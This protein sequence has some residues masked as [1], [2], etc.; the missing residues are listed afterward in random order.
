[1]D[2]VI[3]QLE[4][5]WRDIVIHLGTP[6]FY[7][8]IGL[9][10]VALASAW[11]LTAILRARVKILRDVPQP[12]ALHDVRRALHTVARVFLISENA[13]CDGQH[14]S[15]IV[16]HQIGERR[17]VPGAKTIEQ[18]L[19]R[20]VDRPGIGVLASGCAR[21]VQANLLVRARELP[22]RRV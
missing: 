5:A 1:M 22:V 12:G 9:V 21:S 4:A 18:R 15:A 3:E 20:L 7:A 2:R 6:E 8:Q 11:V 10:I 19:L 17:L 14:R 16:R 13:P